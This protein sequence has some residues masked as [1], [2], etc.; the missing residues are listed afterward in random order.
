MIEQFLPRCTASLAACWYAMNG[1]EFTAVNSFLSEYLPVLEGIVQHHSKYRAVAAGLASQGHQ[2]KGLL[3]LHRNDWQ[4]REKHNQQAVR[5]ARESGDQTLLVAALM[6]YADTF[7]YTGSISSM[8]CAYQD[9]LR[10]INLVPPLLQGR[11]HAGLADAYALLG[12]KQEAECS[13]GLVQMAFSEHRAGD[14]VMPYIGVSVFTCM[15][16]QGLVRLDLKQPRAAWETFEQI[17]RF[18]QTSVIPE[19][20]GLE[21]INHQAKVA[22]AMREMEL[23]CDYVD[24]GGQ[25]AR[26][27]GSQKRWQEAYTIY[28]QGR[29]IWPHEARVEGLAQKF[30]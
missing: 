19:R 15:M 5:Y 24:R 20:I 4:E 27:L 21:I 16:W 18:Q 22:L 14:Q 1:S 29:K 6:K 17:K 13:L 9:A 26:A 12:E 3:A 25:G 28:G 7:Y 11:I 10:S 2:L 8:L 23:F 30:L